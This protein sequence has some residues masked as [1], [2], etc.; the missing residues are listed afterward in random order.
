MELARLSVRPSV[1]LSVPYGLVE[2]KTAQK[3]NEIGVPLCLIGFTA[4]LLTDIRLRFMV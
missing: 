1:L 4:M 2:T 3:K